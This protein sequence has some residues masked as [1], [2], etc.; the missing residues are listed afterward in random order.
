VSTFLSTLGDCQSL[1][2]SD[3]FACLPSTFATSGTMI[4]ARRFSVSRFWADCRR[5]NADS[6]LY[7]GEMVRYL[8]QAPPDPHFPDPKKMHNIKVCYGLGLSPPAW[9]ALREKFGV[10][11]I[12]EYYSA[13]EATAAICHSN[14]P[15]NDE[16]VGHIARWG[17]LMRSSWFGQ[18]SLYIIRTDA[19][20]G[21]PIRNT[22]GLSEQVGFDEKGEAIARIEPPLRR[23]HDYVGEGGAEA[24]EKKMLRNVFKHGDTF[25]KTGDAI[26]IVSPWPPL[27]PTLPH[28]QDPRK[29]PR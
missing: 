4:L 24:T 21:E 20:T 26:S 23:K 22:K 17:P 12:I 3:R 15:G 19:E 10:P 8:V 28:K 9:R 2:Y 18:D 27:P 6:F 16:G 11:W 7:I 25:M 29:V 1:F 14:K 13:S 5:S